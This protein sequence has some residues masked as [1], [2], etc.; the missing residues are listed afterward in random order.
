MMGA[1]LFGLRRGSVVG[2]IWGG[3]KVVSRS[4]RDDATQVRVG[5][6]T[7]TARRMLTTKRRSSLE[8]K[9]RALVNSTLGDAYTTIKLACVLT[10][11]SKHL[12]L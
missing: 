3:M 6:A 8:P 12:K 1:R 7:A 10:V 11:A 9:L 4:A 2:S 5:R